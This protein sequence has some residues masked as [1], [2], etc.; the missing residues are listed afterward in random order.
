MTFLEIIVTLQTKIEIVK[1]KIG[2]KRICILTAV[3]LMT[4]VNVWAQKIQTVDDEGHGIPLVSVLTEDGVLIGTTDINGVLA[5]VKGAE[6][7]AVTHVAFKPQLVVVS[8]LKDGLIQME[9]VT[10]SL[11][12]VEVKQKPY[13]FIEYYFRGFSY[14]GDSLR[15][16]A[17]GII[18]VGHEI[19]NNYKGKTRNVWSFGGAANKALTWNTQDL[20]LMAEKGAKSAAWPIELSARKGKKFQ[21]YYKTTIEA[22]GDHRW[23]LKNPEG[24][25]GHFMHDNGLYRAT[26]DGG[27]MQVY[28]NKANGETRIAKLRENKDYDYQYSEVFK[29]EEDGTLQPGS[30][31]MEVSHWE[32]NSGKGRRI[33]VIYLYATDKGYY[34]QD[35]FKARSKELNKGRSGD[36]TLDELAEYERSHNIPALSPEQ[37]KAIQELTKQTGK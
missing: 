31:V 5:D 4:A 12:E 32:Y 14:I 27:K 3:A 20:A 10:Y 30:F 16:Y 18:P 17:S 13:L 36:M 28:A 15:A 9:E 21:D 24:V 33:T 1:N 37:I 2:M 29:F 35:E 22:D 19:Q 25:V 8:S 26:I 34:D 23:L 7:V 11:A 6:K